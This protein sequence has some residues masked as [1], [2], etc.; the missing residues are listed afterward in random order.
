MS[1]T[2]CSQELYDKYETV[3]RE[4]D[5]GELYQDS[6]L[7]CT[8]SI[9]DVRKGMTLNEVR[10][11]TGEP[12]EALELTKEGSKKSI[13]IWNY[14]HEENIDHSIEFVD[15]KVEDVIEEYDAYQ[16]EAKKLLEENGIKPD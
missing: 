14:K 1:S 15:G 4:D 2:L 12:S 5:K 11:I 6:I 10:E 16:N 7:E 13:E 8:L 3:W 9:H